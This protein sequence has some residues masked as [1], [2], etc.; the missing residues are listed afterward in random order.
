MEISWRGE[1]RKT[2]LDVG[3]QSKQSINPKR[4]ENKGYIPGNDCKIRE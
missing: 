2:F 4:M 1:A 3:Y